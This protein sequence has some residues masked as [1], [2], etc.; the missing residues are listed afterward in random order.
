MKLSKSRTPHLV[1]SSFLVF[2][3]FGLD[4]LTGFVKLLLTTRL[5]GTGPEIDAFATANQLPELL[6]ALIAAG[7]LSAAFIPVYSGYLTQARRREAESL[8]GTVLTLTLIAMGAAC[9]LAILAAPWLVR[10]VLAPHFP[11]ETQLLTVQMMRIFLMAAGLISISGVLGSVLH[12][13][14]HFLTPALGRVLIDLGQIT[15]MIL[16]VPIWGVYGMAWGSVLG[17][18]LTILVQLPALA[19][20]R[21]RLR[22]QI[23]L[24]LEGVREVLRLMGPRIVTL[25]A[26]Q[27]VDL[28]FI[29]LASALP[30]GSI[31]AF[32][33]ALLVMLSMPK[34]LFGAA[35]ST[36]IFPTM[37]EQYNVGSG[38]RLRQTVTHGLRATWL[39]LLP[40][41]LGLLVLG[42]PAVAFLFE[43]GSFGP[44]SSAL[45]YLLM[46]IFSVRLLGEASYDVLTLTFFAQHNT[47]VPMW[48]TLGW[49]VVNAGLSVLLVGPFGIAGLAWATSIAGAVLAATM[50]GLNLRA[51]GVDVSMLATT[52]RRALASS[53]GMCGVVL[54]LHQL[55]MPPALF[56]L[57]GASGGGF[58]F[59]GIY[60]LLGGREI[61]TVLGHLR[62]GLQGGIGLKTQSN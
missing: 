32:H 25:G 18:A 54:L 61:L 13:H 10:V 59:F 45:V 7:A 5:F 23:N 14:Q 46:A 12:S 49:T 9:F 41:G 29:R 35:I 36:V 28:V 47:H 2:F 26:F 34:S 1:R 57:A 39:L 21:V 40:A 43:R 58:A 15:G 8:A 3:I 62:R 4:K 38:Q 50:F 48:A 56:I 17:A 31:A 52:L 20:Q 60:V 16:L 6:L 30:A 19:R 11:V 22:L 44:E 51:G 27:A 42:R 55:R 33:Y 24:R 53:L 37:A